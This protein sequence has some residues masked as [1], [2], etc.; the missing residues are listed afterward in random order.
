MHFH[1]V[2]PPR[3]ARLGWVRFPERSGVG[4]AR[5]LT[6]SEPHGCVRPLGW[7]RKLQAMEQEL[8]KRG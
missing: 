3:R 2:S 7:K 6:P 5:R 1:D 8:L 4:A